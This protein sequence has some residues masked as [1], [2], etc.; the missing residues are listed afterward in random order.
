MALRFFQV[1]GWGDSLVLWNTSGNDWWHWPTGVFLSDRIG[2]TP[3]SQPEKFRTRFLEL[4]SG[5]L[6]SLFLLEWSWVCRFVQIFWDGLSRGGS[7][8]FFHLDALFDRMMYIFVVLAKLLQILLASG[9]LDDT[10]R[11]HEAVILLDSIENMSPGWVKGVNIFGSS[12]N[13]ALMLPCW[14]M[15]YLVDSIFSCAPCIFHL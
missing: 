9:C 13:I 14:S 15:Q 6:F 12:T 10:R 5:G 3:Y 2:V 7:Q 11:S 1:F 4:S 8:Y